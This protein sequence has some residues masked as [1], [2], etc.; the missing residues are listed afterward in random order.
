[1]LIS[2]A[3]RASQSSVS[4]NN[5]ASPRLT[6]KVKRRSASGSVAHGLSRRASARTPICA[7][8]FHANAWRRS[9]TVTL[10]SE[11]CIFDTEEGERFQQLSAETFRRI[12]G[13]R[14]PGRSEQ[15]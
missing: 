5:R 15:L 2:D 14:P 12:V 6:W 7:H 3:F 9:A 10:S 1:M 11:I 13:D 4:P 8:S